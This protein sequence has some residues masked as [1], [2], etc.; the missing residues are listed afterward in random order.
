M[1]DFLDQLVQSAI[2]LTK[3]GHVASYIPELQ[4]A[5]PSDVAIVV[6]DKYNQTSAAGV[7]QKRFTIQSVSKIISLIYAL[8]TLGEEEVFNHIGMEQTADPFN[9]IIKLETK[10]HKPLNPLIN[11]GAIATIGT[12]VKHEGVQAFQNLLSFTQRLAKDT[13]IDLNQEVYHS[14]QETGDIN[15]ALAYFQKGKGNIT[16]DIDL[17]LETYFKMCSL[18]VTCV[19]LAQIGLSLALN[20]RIGVEQVYSRRTAW[21]A[22]A[23]MTTCGMYDGSGQFSVEVGL[24]AK[25]GVGGGILLCVPGQMGIATFGPSLDEKGNSIAGMDM[26]KKLSQQHDLSMF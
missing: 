24:P 8:E 3:N 26:L 12:I 16:A 19:N 9:S 7:S 10:S 15:R 23:I 5:D 2:P 18:N 6:I 25:S 11:A 4:K 20:G 14:E 1:Q 22:K 17:V 21:I 13:G